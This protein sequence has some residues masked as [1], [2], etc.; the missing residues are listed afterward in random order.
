MIKIEEIT[1][2]IL[3][4]NTHEIDINHVLDFEQRSDNK[5]FVGQWTR[6]QHL[7]SLYQEDILHLIVEDRITNRPVG[8]VIMAG[9]TNPNHN[10]EFRRFVI[11]DK[12]KGFGRETIKSVK[13]ISFQQL[14]THRLWLDVRT[15]NHIA[16][17]LYASEGFIEEGILRDCIYYNGCYESLMIM[18][19]LENEYI[20]Q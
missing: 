1:K 19:L 7:L 16:R 3:L 2:R 13:K 14:H 8:Y 6:E 11:S 9:L 12:G 18:S 15:K 5:P 17:H 10:L 4:R 20:T